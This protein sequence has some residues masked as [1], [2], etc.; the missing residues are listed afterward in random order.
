MLGYLSLFYKIW[1]IPIKYNYNSKSYITVFCKSFTV[2]SYVCIWFCLTTAMRIYTSM[3]Y[4]VQ[5][6]T[7][8]THLK[9]LVLFLCFNSWLWYAASK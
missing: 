8:G 5:Q 4:T 6:S 2:F 1:Y 7:A 3:P 9:A